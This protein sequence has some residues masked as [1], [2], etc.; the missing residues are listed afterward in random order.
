MYNSTTYRVIHIALRAHPPRSSLPPSPCI[1]PLYHLLPPQRPLVITLLLTIWDFVRFFIC[2]FLFY[3]THDSNSALLDFVVLIMTKGKRYKL[4]TRKYH[5]YFLL[6]SS[7]WQALPQFLLSWVI[8]N[9]PLKGGV[10]Q[11]PVQILRR[12]LHLTEEETDHVFWCSKGSRAL[13]FQ[14]CVSPSWDVF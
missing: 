2:R 10:F 1:W 13:N 4:H 5:Q 7:L 9:L 6:F 12:A 3:I 8:T 14:A 11:E